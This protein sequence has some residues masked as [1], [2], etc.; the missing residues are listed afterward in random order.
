MTAI[1]CGFMVFRPT[2]KAV[3]YSVIPAQAGI[4]PLFLHH[5]FCYDALICDDPDE[6]DPISLPAEI[7]A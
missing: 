4:R 3:G 5:F 7:D 1:A 6:I 2:A